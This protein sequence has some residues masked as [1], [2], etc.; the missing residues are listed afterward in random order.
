MLVSQECDLLHMVRHVLP[1]ND[2]PASLIRNVVS[3]IQQLLA[4]G[5]LKDCLPMQLEEYGESMLQALFELSCI[6]NME[7]T[8]HAMSILLMDLALAIRVPKACLMK[9]LLDAS[10]FT[11]TGL[12]LHVLLDDFSDS[13]SSITRGEMFYTTYRKVLSS[14]VARH[15]E[16]FVCD[17][18]P[19][20]SNTRVYRIVLDSATAL[21]S[22]GID[23]RRYAEEYSIAFLKNITNIQAWWNMT[24]STDN[25]VQALQLICTA[26]DGPNTRPSTSVLVAPSFVENQPNFYIVLHL[27]KQFLEDRSIDISNKHVA[28]QLI[29]YLCQGS[30]STRYECTSILNAFCRS[31]FPVR[32]REFNTDPAKHREYIAAIDSI[33]EAMVRSGS[34]E[35][36]EVKTI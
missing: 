5:L 22:S 11:R 36:L 26:F 29:G 15:F 1:K 31:S 32:S 25:H 35:L 3:G 12:S 16:D 21:S 24:T 14:Y 13:S 9:L 23:M 10:A 33:L 28:F 20:I 6:A 2:V 4:A 8:S 30:A 17:L 7:P 27:L 19:M 34:C 18:L